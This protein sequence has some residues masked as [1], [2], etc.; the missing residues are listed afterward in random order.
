VGALIAAPGVPISSTLQRAVE[1]RFDLRDI[2]ELLGGSPQLERP[3]GLA[4]ARQGF[5]QVVVG[6][7]QLIAEALPLL[8]SQ[9]RR[10]VDEPRRMPHDARVDVVGAVVTVQRGMAGDFDVHLIVRQPIDEL[11]VTFGS[12]VAL[13]GLWLREQESDGAR[14]QRPALCGR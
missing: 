14:E 8:G 5:C 13:G 12:G 1:R 6:A 9:A 10:D 7:R 2:G 3:I 11:H 4:L